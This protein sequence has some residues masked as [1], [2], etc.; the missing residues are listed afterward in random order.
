M[1][2]WYPKFV[3]IIVLCAK[4]SCVMPWH[5]CCVNSVT[6]AARVGTLRPERIAVEEVGDQ[7]RHKEQRARASGYRPGAKGQTWPEFFSAQRR[8]EKSLLLNM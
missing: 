4:R 3:P 8:A 1:M 7:G 5:V 6:P 2:H